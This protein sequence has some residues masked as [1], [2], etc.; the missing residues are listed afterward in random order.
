M[1]CFSGNTRLL[2]GAP[3]RRA[4]RVPENAPISAAMTAKQTPSISRP[5]PAVPSF[6]PHFSG[7]RPFDERLFPASTSTK[8]TQ[9]APKTGR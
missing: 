1:L 9:R 4:L 6:D 7:G 5:K 3:L 2:T 8:P